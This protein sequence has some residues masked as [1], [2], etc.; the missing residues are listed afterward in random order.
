MDNLKPNDPLHDKQPGGTNFPDATDITLSLMNAH[1]RT[2]S[3]R[4][5]NRLIRL[6]KILLQLQSRRLITSQ[7]LADKFGI[8]QR[9][10]YRD[11]RALEEAGVPVIGEPGT[12]YSLPD[13][14]RV[15]PVMFNESEI[16][17]LLTARE[18]IHSNPDRSLSETFDS[19]VLKIKGLLKYKAKEQTERIEQRIR[20][21]ELEE[22]NKTNFLSLILLCISNNILLEIKYHAIYS[23]QV[24]EREVEPLAVYYTRDK[25]LL[26][27]FCRM[28]KALR[29]FRVDR[30]IE[31]QSAN[32]IF[33]ERQFTFEEY[34]IQMTKK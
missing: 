2:P 11:I 19:L 25:W 17:A 8:S 30:I 12:G 23:D 31:L 34:V 13:D 21:Y 27:G 9:T 4:L 3:A 20:I 16:T 26:I 6:T 18:Y 28:R 5:M 14:Y 32:R 33:Q 10:I 24:S 22:G 7:V 15:P 29:E 1:L